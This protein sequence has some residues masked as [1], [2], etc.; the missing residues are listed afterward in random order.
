MRSENFMDGLRE[1]P[2]AI[3]NGNA[4]MCIYAQALVCTCMC[5][6]TIS[7]GVDTSGR[8]ALPAR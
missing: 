4:Y 1:A 8:C 2:T 5:I 6:Y 7:P 3:Y